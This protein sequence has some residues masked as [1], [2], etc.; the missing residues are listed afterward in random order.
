M[1]QGLAVEKTPA[2]K[3]K[4]VCRANRLG[5]SW[6]PRLALRS[7]QLLA[8]RRG[9]EQH[10]R[11]LQEAG[12]VVRK[13]VVA[14]H[15]GVLRCA[16]ALLRTSAE[17]GSLMAFATHETAV[18]ERDALETANRR[19]NGL[20]LLLARWLRDVRARTLEDDTDVLAG[21]PARVPVGVPISAAHGFEFLGAHARRLTGPF[22][23]KLSS[24][25]LQMASRGVCLATTRTCLL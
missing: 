9:L 12:V 8:R 15:W 17:K 22:L 19:V 3:G 10:P 5:S 25:A 7:R 2:S 13:A 23:F 18:C 11:A 21:G 20:A 4:I 14:A 6:T 24:L 1:D 16:D